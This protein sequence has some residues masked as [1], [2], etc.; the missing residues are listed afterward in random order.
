MHFYCERCKKEYP[1]ATHAYACECG[2]LFRLYQSAMDAGDR[3]EAV[4]LG[5][6]ETPLLPLV[7][8]GCRFYFKMED[9]QP[10]GS[11][12]DRGAK[13]LI[14][15]LAHLGIDRVAVDSA[16]NA[17][18]AVAA[19]AAAAGI[20]CRVYVPDDISAERAKQITAY[21][22]DVVRVPNGRMNASSVLRGELGSDYYASHVYNPLFADGIKSMAHEI[23]HELG[24]IVPDYIF[25]PVGN[26]SLLLGLYQGFAEIGRLP[27]FVGVQSTKCAPVVEAFHDL[28][29]TPR[30]NTIAETIRVGAP[31]RMDDILKA[32]RRSGGDAVAVEDSEILKAAKTLNRRGIYAELTAAAGLAGAR[33]FFADGMPDNYRVIIPVPGS[34][35]KR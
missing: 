12:K 23:Y 27:H 16:G 10:T 29:E 31:P 19:Y 18:A 13:R 4:T 3:H 8:D 21:G 20:A 25:V 15:E 30:K 14:G 2:G 7:I 34:G 6:V 24:D 5:E 35:L 1:V 32:L 28:P 9:R 22:A 17:G 11:F 33:A 26:G